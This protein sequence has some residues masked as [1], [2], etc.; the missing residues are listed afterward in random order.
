MLEQPYNSAEPRLPLAPVALALGNDQDGK[1]GFDGCFCVR[2][3]RRRSRHAKAG[4]IIAPAGKHAVL[5]VVV[6]FYIPPVFLLL[7][8][9]KKL[10]NVSDRF[11]Q[12]Y[13]GSSTVS[14]RVLIK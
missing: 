6:C 9:C 11:F 1:H 2:R 5:V 12:R 3:A 7:K 10:G 13:L 8:G 14:G 4:Q